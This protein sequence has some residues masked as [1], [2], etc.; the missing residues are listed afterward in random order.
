MAS[1]HRTVSWGCLLAADCLLSPWET[2]GRRVVCARHPL[3]VSSQESSSSVGAVVV[4]GADGPFCSAL[5]IAGH[6]CGGYPL[7]LG[8]GTPYIPCLGLARLPLPFVALR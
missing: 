4:C 6:C 2:T 8:L 7:S 5:L 3:A 1:S